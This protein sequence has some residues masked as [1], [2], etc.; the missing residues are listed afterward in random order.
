MLSGKLCLF[1]VV[2]FVVL[3]IVLFVV[4]SVEV[5]VSIWIIAS[6]IVF[7]AISGGPWRFVFASAA[8]DDHFGS[9]LR[10]RLRGT[11]LRGFWLGLGIAAAVNG[12]IKAR[13]RTAGFT[14]FR[15]TIIFHIQKHLLI[16]TITVYERKIKSVPVKKGR[17][18]Q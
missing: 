6:A 12:Y 3:V 17:N 1:A 8:V 16:R 18:A 13:R 2:L 11:W 4:F 10:P 14:G 15:K 7:A 5:S 9:G